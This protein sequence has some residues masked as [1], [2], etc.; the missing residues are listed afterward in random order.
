MLL[1]FCALIFILSVF[2]KFSESG[3]ESSY[4][5][6]L[7]YKKWV[8]L[9]E[10]SGNGNDWVGS[11]GCKITLHF[12]DVL[13]GSFSDWDAFSSAHNSLRFCTR[14][15]VEESSQVCFGSEIHSVPHVKL[16]VGR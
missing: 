1:S 15:R 12:A 4:R 2:G 16:G 11:W 5:I 9:G 13:I 3:R 7:Q 8:G 14:V 10:C 6:W